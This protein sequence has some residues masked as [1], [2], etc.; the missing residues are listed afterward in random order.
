MRRGPAAPDGSAGDLP[1]VLGARAAP[2][3]GP[4][5]LAVAGI[6]GNETAGVHAVRAVLARLAE[7]GLPR[8]GEVVAFA[9]NLG[10]LA[11][12]VRYVAKDLNRAWT[13]EREASL[14]GP[15]GLPHPR[16]AEDGEHAALEAAL[17]EAVARARGPAFLVD[18]HTTSGEGV[19]FVAA[20]ESAESA[21]FAS[22][23]PLTVLESLTG[24]LS[25]TM[26]EAMV[27]RGV[28]A[29]VVENGQ[30]ADP[31]SVAHAE[32]AL[33]IALVASG[34]LD[35]EDA[36]EAEWGRRLLARVRGTLPRSIRVVYRHAIEP[37]DHFV[38]R[39]GWRH[40]RRVKKGQVL[41]DDARGE[42]VATETGY[43][44]LPLYQALG[45][46]GFFLGVTHAPGRAR[47][48]GTPAEARSPRVRR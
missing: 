46:D 7:R 48:A 33:W 20:G 27:A 41:A 13:P 44:L 1:R 8:R 9:G 18:L 17:L 36:P 37:E 2:A 31:R 34:V 23:V 5:L 25:G 38:M 35:S 29:M 21:A 24:R 39:P 12:G 28:A 47:S 4:T 40:F 42:V 15:G 3:P 43:L 19:P 14:A 22:A 30:N 16:D 10:A 32:A 26:V 45:D 6:H 11:R